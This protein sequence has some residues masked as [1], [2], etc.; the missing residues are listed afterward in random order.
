M[1]AEAIYYRDY[2]VQIIEHPA[3][4]WE[5][6]I[7]P[8]KFGLPILPS[9]IQKAMSADRELA[10]AEAKAHV[11]D[12]LGERGAGRLAVPVNQREQ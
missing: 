3:N 2:Q 12:L 10:I 9:W 4:Q 11:D 5:V 8:T 1:N 6:H 7:H